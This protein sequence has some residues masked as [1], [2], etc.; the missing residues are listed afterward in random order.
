M[1]K[2]LVQTIETAINLEVASARSVRVDILPRDVAF[3]IP[4]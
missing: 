4:D 3:Q 1:Q 2:E